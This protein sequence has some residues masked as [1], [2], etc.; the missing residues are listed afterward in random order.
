VHELVAVPLD[1]SAADD[2]SRVRVL[3]TGPDFVHSPAVAGHG[4]LAW[5]QWDHPDMPWDGHRTGGG[6]RVVA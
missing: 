3:V 5:V 1:G 4:R 6:H 2:P